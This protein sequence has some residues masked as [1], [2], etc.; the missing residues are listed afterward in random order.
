MG[1]L[2]YS[3]AKW[4]RC[5]SKWETCWG[6]LLGYILISPEMP[7]VETGKWNGN[8]PRMKKTV[9][10]LEPPSHWGNLLGKSS[11]SQSL[12]KKPI[13]RKQQ[14]WLGR[15]HKDWE[16]NIKLVKSLILCYFTRLPLVD[17]TIQ[18]FRIWLSVLKMH[19]W[20][21]NVFLQIK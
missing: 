6:R 9:R 13:H 15:K 7:A 10:S 17:D 8:F 14:V 21:L 16:G 12:G 18:A 2:H 1:S 4:C 19:C 20:N 5:S 3:L 11:C